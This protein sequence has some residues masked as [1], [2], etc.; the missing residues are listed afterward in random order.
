VT[1]NSISIGAGTIN[2]IP[3]DLIYQSNRIVDFYIP[4][5]TDSSITGITTPTGWSYTIDNVDLF[6]L[7]A[8]TLHWTANLSG[9]P[10][11]D[12]LSGFGYTAS[13][14]A[15]KAP[16]QVMIH[17]D[18]GGLSLPSGG[19]PLIPASPDAIVAGLKP[20]DAPAAVPEPATIL[21]FGGGLVAVG[22][23]RKRG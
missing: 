5:F 15:A 23:I 2:G 20:V 14:S 4:Y 3:T 21:L 22:L 12:A 18:I 9:I 13:Y 16:Y 17:T 19:D 10:L 7:S 8:E 1:N 6:N 11:G